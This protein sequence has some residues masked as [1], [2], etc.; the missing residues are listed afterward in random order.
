[1]KRAILLNLAAATLLI[2]APSARAQTAP[3]SASTL[4]SASGVIVDSL[5]ESPLV[6]A[7]VIIEGTTRVGFTDQDGRYQIDSIPP[8]Q[9]RV[10]VLHAVL[11]TVGI[12]LRTPEIGFV[13]GKNHTLDISI[14]GPQW[15]ASR[16]CNAAQQTLGP[17]ALV[18]FVKDPDTNMPMVGAKV[19]LVYEVTDVI[20]RKT[21]RVRSGMTDSTGIYRICGIPGD[22]S[23]KVQVFR[24]GV[25]SGEVPAEITNGFLGLRAFSIVSEHANVVAVTNDSGKVRYVAKGAAKVTGRVVDKLGKPLREARVTIQGGDKPV[26]TN[27]NG[28]F[29]LDSLPSGTQAL[30]VRKLGYAVTEIPVELSTLAAATANVTMSDAVPLLETMRTEAAADQV[31]SDLGYLERKNSGFG[32][33]LDGKQINHDAIMFTD[34]MYNVPG[35]RVSPVGNGRDYTV[36]DT[37]NAANGCVNFFV[38][39]FPWPEMTPGDINNYVRPGETVAVEV[40]HGSNTPPQ[41]QKSGQSSCASIVIWTQAKVSTMAKKKAKKP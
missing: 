35:L 34:I 23:G 21:P 40:Y 29:T 26:L 27:A 31:L 4:S 38:D 17:A 22:M 39:G 20:G 28:F 37:R 32:Y 2:A 12:T 1:M 18:G 30:E 8:G 3:A 10:R 33:F 15:M 14:P 13:A 11:D 6:H 5:H 7:N 25:A 9:H 36:R 16:F 19:E 41:F 24:N